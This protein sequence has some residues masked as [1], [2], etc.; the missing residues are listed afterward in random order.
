MDAAAGPQGAEGRAYTAQLG[1][2]RRAGRFRQVWELLRRMGREEVE[3]N[4]FHCS[5][6]ISA[7]DATNW[8]LALQ[9]LRAMA[10][11][12]VPPNIVS[13]NVCCS[14]LKT[15]WG[16]AV[17]LLAAERQLQLSAVTYSSAMTTWHV[18]LRL[19]TQMALRQVPAD[20]VC[21]GSLLAALASAGCWLVAVQL[22]GQI[23]PNTIM[24]NSAISA[25]EKGHKWQ[26]ALYF[27]AQ[28]KE[29]TVVSFS[30]ALSA[31]ARSARWEQALSLLHVMPS[32][33]VVANSVSFNA[34]IT[35][36]E[37]AQ[38]WDLALQLLAQMARLEAAPSVVS[39]NAALSACGR[40][41]WRMALHLL[42]AMPAE[43]VEPDNATFSSA[44]AGCAMGRRWQQA[45]ELLRQMP[46]RGQS[47][48]PGSDFCHAVQDERVSCAIFGE[49]LQ[50]TCP[51]WKNQACVA[52][53]RL[54]FAPGLLQRLAE[55]AEL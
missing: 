13:L 2:L 14:A 26:W 39:F 49:S 51:V 48:L 23:R 29:A 35:A 45:L 38:R 28:M 30:A 20:S 10:A 46:R 25:C 44:I 37:K 27:L 52:C 47:C 9:T 4:V 41:Q 6:A 40:S 36:A 54:A 31:C 50:P 16:R 42:A 53:G 15:T 32:A 5:C 8:P 12:Q 34:A 7:C 18:G 19:F 21:H 24:Y 22:L 1:R 33:R 3:T 11:R 17:E 43:S 55:L